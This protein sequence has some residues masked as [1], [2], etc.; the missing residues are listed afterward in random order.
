MNIVT[1]T[2]DGSEPARAVP[3]GRERVDWVDTAKGVCIILV[4]MMHA[5]LGVGAE[6][7]REGFVHALVAF[8]KPFR[9]P[10][11]FLVSGLFLWRV[12]D[13]DWRSYADKRVLHFAYFYLLWLVIQSGFKYGQVS[14]GS[15]A[16]FIQ[17]I[18]HGLWEPYSTLWFIYLLAVFSVVTKLLRPLPRPVVLALAAAL[19][20]LPV[21]TGSLV[22]DEFCERWVYFLAGAMLAGPIFRVAGWAVEHKAV[23]AVS[24]AGWA[25]V[26]GALA[27]APAAALVAGRAGTLAE[28]PVVSLMLGL[29][30]ALAIITAASLATASRGARAWVEPLRYC[31]RH[32]IAIYLAFFLPMA[33]AR[34][35]LVRSGWIADVGL[36]S[37]LVTAAAIVA[38]LALEFL[39][40]DTRWSFLFV[41]PA[42]LGLRRRVE[43]AA[44]PA[45]AGVTGSGSSAPEQQA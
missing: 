21:A 2:R 10:D 23:V 27:F 36:V 33:L 44:L 30:G 20:I 6:M 5:T 42:W 38:P 9:M 40:R 18:V 26:N 43:S 17:H 25:I 31:G 19:Q 16:G 37:A 35:V 41:R 14:G 7:G 12:I 29:A 1:Y 39:V 34:T 28:Q 3:D 32:S 11:F 45:R 15:P 8:S 24:L 4:V 13:R 22:I